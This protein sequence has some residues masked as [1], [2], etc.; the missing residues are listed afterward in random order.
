MSEY[1]L[2]EKIAIAIPDIFTDYKG[3]RWWWDDVE[4][5]Y[6]VAI[7]KALVERIQAIMDGTYSDMGKLNEWLDTQ[8]DCGYCEGDGE[9]AECKYRHEDDD[10]SD[11]ECGGSGECT[12]CEGTGKVLLEEE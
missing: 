11:C 4:P 6:Q 10:T 3:F 8:L 2:A 9:C 5:Q 1:T 7:H 12:H